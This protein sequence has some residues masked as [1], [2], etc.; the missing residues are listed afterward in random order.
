MT[1]K[2]AQPRR[3]EESAEASSGARAAIPV[4]EFVGDRIRLRRSLIGLTQEQLSARLNISYQQIQK[5]ET[6]ANRVS[7]GRLYQI[8][9]VLGVDVGYFYQGYGAPIEETEQTA[10]S[11]RLTAD[12]VRNFN[13]I[14]DENI[15]Q[16]IAALTRSVA[17]RS[18]NN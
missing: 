4:D 1:E 11:N 15:R 14:A 17:E 5:Y 6:G 13:E 8:S 12:L 16:A 10:V 9:Q 18:Q 7:A 3:K 2:A